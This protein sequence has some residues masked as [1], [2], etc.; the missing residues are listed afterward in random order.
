MV[1]NFKQKVER[2]YYGTFR[3]LIFRNYHHCVIRQTQLCCSILKLDIF[4]G[5]LG[6]LNWLSFQLQLR[7]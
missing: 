7:S 1:G 2:L 5:H 6:W 4:M 3:D